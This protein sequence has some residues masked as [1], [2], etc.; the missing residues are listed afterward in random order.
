MRSSPPPSRPQW[1]SSGS[2]PSPG[3]SWRGPCGGRGASRSTT[4]K[5]DA[6]GEFALIARLAAAL[7]TAGADGSVGAGGR[8]A[9]GGPNAA[10]VILGI[11]DDVAVLDL[12]GPE[13]VLATV[14]AQVEGVH[15]RAD[16]L[17]PADIGHRALAASASDIA[18]CGGRPRHAL[19]ALAIRSFEERSDAS[20]SAVGSHD[21][22]RPGT[23]GAWWE[24]VYRGL[25]EAAARWGIAVVGGNIARIGGPIVIDV[26]MLGTAPPAHIV[27]RDGARAGDRVV[28]VGALGAAAAGL[29]VALDK[30]G[31]GAF[32]ARLTPSDRRT[33]LRAWRR[34]IPQLAAAATIAASGTAT[35]MIDVSDGLTADVGHICDASGVGVE[36]VAARLP[37]PPAARRAAAFVG[38]AQ[39]EA[40][41][42]GGG[43]DYALCLTVG[44]HAVDD[45]VDRV[46]AAGARAV[47][48]GVVLPAGEERRVVGADGDVQALGDGGWRHV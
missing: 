10:D 19:V 2:S 30:S 5:S 24:A 13:H 9:S 6:G 45:L 21:I 8:L 39:A 29:H 41:A 12:G 20:R 43:E 7:R 23:D 34:P 31:D 26:T 25:G 46:R 36:L 48:V 1:R 27:R 40:W 14:D 18:A 32:A 3:R 33:L 42:L 44:P 47:D 38:P 15:W 16:L 4:A 37:I 28:V 11:G 35:A 22:G 17:S